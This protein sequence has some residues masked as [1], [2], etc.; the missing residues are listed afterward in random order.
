MA[1]KKAPA[2]TGDAG[3]PAVDAG[4]AQLLPGP[5]ILPTGPRGAMVAEIHRFADFGALRKNK[6]LSPVARFVE[7]AT[8]ET[9][10][11]RKLGEEVARMTGEPL[12]PPQEIVLERLDLGADPQLWRVT[13]EAWCGKGVEGAAGYK[14]DHLLASHQGARWRL[15]QSY[16]RGCGESGEPEVMLLDIDGDG[17]EDVVASYA[18]TRLGAEN[19]LELKLLRRTTQGFLV[20]PLLSE[21]SPFQTLEVRYRP[22]SGGGRDLVFRTFREEAGGCA[23]FEVTVLYTLDHEKMVHL[24]GKES[25]RAVSPATLIAEGEDIDPRCSRP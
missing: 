1:C 14:S 19:R 4:A 18:S 3:A 13:Y 5:R 6:D 21:G 17:R 24:R 20:Q 12:R 7:D 8:R 16:R 9:Y 23:F 25:L 15:V 11:S 2:A 10:G 22:A